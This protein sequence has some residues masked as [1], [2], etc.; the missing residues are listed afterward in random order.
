MPNFCTNRITVSHTDP[1]RIRALAAAMRRGNFLDHV[2]PVHQDL[3]ITAGTK[4]NELEQ[5]QLELLEES[6]IERFGY[7]NWYDFCVNT[8]GTKW[9]VECDDVTEIDSNTVVAQFESAW[10][11]PLGVYWKL[12]EDGFTVCAYYLEEGMEFVGKWQDGE[13]HYYEYSGQT[14]KTIR[15][16]VGAELD[17]EFNLSEMMEWQEEDQ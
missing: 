13:D 3:K 15:D 9:D 10:S 2:I 5:T 4:G 11:P 7:S 14:S 8:W 17:D 6:N 1:D 16:F 12:E